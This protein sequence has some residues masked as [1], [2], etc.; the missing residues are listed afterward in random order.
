MLDQG[1]EGRVLLHLTRV[2]CAVT[3][4]ASH[5]SLSH[6]DRSFQRGT[7][8]FSARSRRVWDSTRYC[9]ELQGLYRDRLF[10]SDTELAAVKALATPETVEAGK[11]NWAPGLRNRQLLAQVSTQE[12]FCA[13]L[14]H[15]LGHE[16]LPGP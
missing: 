11:D 12:A 7:M 10:F 8:C 15:T 16:L 3:Y 13:Y 9:H 2:L 14:V 5:Q 4:E 6:I 1:C